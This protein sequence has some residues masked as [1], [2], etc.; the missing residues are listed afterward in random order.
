M[1]LSENFT[2]DGVTSGA[3]AIASIKCV[4]CKQRIAYILYYRGYYQ[5]I[6]FLQNIGKQD[7]L[8]IFIYHDSSLKHIYYDGSTI[9]DILENDINQ[10]LI[11]LHNCR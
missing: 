4:I 9:S 3:L 8:E 5:E 10:Y 6:E 7:G 2:F 11:D 1:E